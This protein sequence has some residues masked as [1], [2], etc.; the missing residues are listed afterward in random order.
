MQ[1]KTWLLS[2]LRGFHVM[3]HTV[4]TRRAKLL[5]AS[6]SHS[7]VMFRNAGMFSTIFKLTPFMKNLI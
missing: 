5:A 6:E 3:I 1:Q 2:V 4:P 7:R